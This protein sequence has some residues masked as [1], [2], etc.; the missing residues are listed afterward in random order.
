MFWSFHP[1]AVKTD[2][3]HLPKPFFK[4][5]WKSL[6][7]NKFFFSCLTKLLVAC[8]DLR[9]NTPRDWCI[10]SQY[11]D[12]GNTSLLVC[13]ITSQCVDITEISSLLLA[14]HILLFDS[15]ISFSCYFSVFG[16]QMK[17]S[18][19]CLIYYLSVFGYQMKHSLS[20]LMYYFSVFGYQMKHSFS[21]LIYYLS[22]FGYQMKHSLSHL[23]YYFSVFGYQMKH[24]FSC[25]LDIL[26]IGVLI[27]NE[28]LLPVFNI[29][30]LVIL[31]RLNIRWNTSA[32]L[33]N[34]SA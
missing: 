13:Y 28:T 15:W 21:C 9:W 20:Y 2:N 10:S 27:S 16:Y 8:L 26:L 25:W 17:H 22:V 23:M 32:L 14:F 33:V 19:S 6:Y 30:L 31:L 34:M 1:L 12:I 24:C 4:V 7:R 18:F 11:F 3:E 5:I 29:L